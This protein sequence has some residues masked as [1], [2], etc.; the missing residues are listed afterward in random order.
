MRLISALLPAAMVAM[1]PLAAAPALAADV[2]VVNFARVYEESIAG[3]DARTKLQGV[4]EEI[5]RE[6][7]PAAASVRADQEKLGPRFKDKTPEQQLA[8]LEKDPNLQQAF[9]ATRQ[10]LEQF[11]QLQ[12]LRQQELQATET[13][14]VNAVLA[15][16]E[17]IIKQLLTEKKAA[18]V[19][20]AG[21]AVAVSPA[22]DVTNEVISR[23]NTS[24]KAV[25]VTKVDLIAEQRAAQ[26]RQAQARQN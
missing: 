3:K 24:L 21:N 16:T 17:P 20:E 26:Q 1:S 22:A 18:V 15:G 12:Q 11:V 13:R 4:S 25:P 14:A 6:L 8:E 19:I 9:T 10:K 23:L 2:I 5:R 7:E